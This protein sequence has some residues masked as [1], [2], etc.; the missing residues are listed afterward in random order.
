M[1]F[2]S[3]KNIR[4]TG[5]DYSQTGGYFLTV[6]THGRAPTLSRICPGTGT[7]RASVVLTGFGRIV[8]EVLRAHG[9]SH[10]FT[11]DA[12]TIMPD[13]I[14]MIVFK[15]EPTRMTVGQLIGAVKS[16]CATRW[17]KVCSDRDIPAGEL[18]QRN[19]YDHILRNE[20]DYLEKRKYLEENPDKWGPGDLC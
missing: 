16:S 7:E 17:Y 13:H 10:G 18:W 8:Q 11:L 1:E 9:N 5:Y 6:C 19:Y 2:P 3:R 20:A 14:H 4:L 15:T 12:Y